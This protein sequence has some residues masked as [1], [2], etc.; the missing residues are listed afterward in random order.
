[1]GLPEFNKFLTSITPNLDDLRAVEKEIENNP[2]V[3][4][5]KLSGTLIAIKD[6]GLWRFYTCMY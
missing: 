4:E 6:D 2:D 3:K 1:M 5:I